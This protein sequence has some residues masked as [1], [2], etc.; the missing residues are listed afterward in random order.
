VVLRSLEQFQRRISAHMRYL[1]AGTRPPI[2]PEMRCLLVGVLPGWRHFTV[3]VYFISGVGH[4]TAD[5]S[6]LTY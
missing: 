2:L 1:G 3:E 4:S 5:T 6:G